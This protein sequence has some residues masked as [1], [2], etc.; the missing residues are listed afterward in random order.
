MDFFRKKIILIIIQILILSLFIYI[1]H[2]SVVIDFDSEI[3]IPQSQ[4]IQ[5]LANFVLFRSPSGM[6]FIYISWVIISLIPDF[7]FY[8][9]KKAYSTNLTSFFFPNFFV[10]TF[11]YQHSPN[12]FH[13]NFLFH[14][15]HTILIGLMLT[16]ISLLIYVALKKLRK[17]KIDTQLDDLQSI[18]NNIKSY[19]PN[20]GI[21][22]D[23]IPTF[24]YNCNSKIIIYP[25]ENDK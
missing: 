8:N 2:Y 19:C 1:F 14:L 16:L 17:D 3:S 24:C 11:L 6:V 13:V 4:I 7:F 18:A 20:C 23:S 21:E 5:F 15:V 22:F 25:E 9:F 10:Y 12:Y